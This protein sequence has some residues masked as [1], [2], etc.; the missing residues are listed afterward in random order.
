MSPGPYAAESWNT[1]KHSLFAFDSTHS[2]Y[3]FNFHPNLWRSCHAQP[4][5]TTLEN[6][7]I[8]LYLSVT[9]ALDL[10]SGR[11]LSFLFDRRRMGLRRGRPVAA[12]GDSQPVTSRISPKTGYSRNTATSNAFLSVCPKSVP[13]LVTSACPRAAAAVL[14]AR[15][16]IAQQLQALRLETSVF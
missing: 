3:P 8:F 14:L 16:V 13:C 15:L 10:V 7:S 4:A 9:C 2:A 6:P 11:P 1:I 5:A 12:A